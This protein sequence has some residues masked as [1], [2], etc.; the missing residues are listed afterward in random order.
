MVANGKF[1]V[2]AS[3][4]VPT[5]VRGGIG[6]GKFPAGNAKDAILAVI[7]EGKGTTICFRYFFAMRRRDW[8]HDAAQAIRVLQNAS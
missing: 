5:V 4:D 8:R 2:T 1:T 7:K 6:D 3:A